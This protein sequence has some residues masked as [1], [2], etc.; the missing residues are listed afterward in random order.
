MFFGCAMFNN[1]DN[2]YLSWNY[3]HIATIQSNNIVDDDKFSLF[4][5]NDQVKNPFSYII[6]SMLTYELDNS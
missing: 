6:A 5:T 4:E 1:S 3:A 2:N